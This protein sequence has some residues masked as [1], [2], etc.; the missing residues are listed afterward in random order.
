LVDLHPRDKISQAHTAN[1][2]LITPKNTSRQP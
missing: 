1:I 2:R